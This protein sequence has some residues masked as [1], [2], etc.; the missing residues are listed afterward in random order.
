[1]AQLL[2]EGS[3]VYTIGLDQFLPFFHGEAHSIFTIWQNLH[4][5]TRAGPSNPSPT[6]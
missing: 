4:I 3:E 2:P 1:M 5:F 6:S